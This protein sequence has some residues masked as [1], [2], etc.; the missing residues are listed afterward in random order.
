MLLLPKLFTDGVDAL[1]ALTYPGGLSLLS[2]FYRLV[3][4]PALGRDRIS[5]EAA[6]EYELPENAIAFAS[7]PPN[8]IP[9][10]AIVSMARWRVSSTT[11]G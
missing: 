6:K 11:K 5:L 3:V 7:A 8:I 9:I 1:L 2:L 4:A 10:P